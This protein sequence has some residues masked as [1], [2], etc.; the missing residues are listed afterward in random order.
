MTRKY[1]KQYGWVEVT[2]Q[3]STFLTAAVAG[4]GL[5]GGRGGREHDRGLGEVL[6]RE[7][8][9]QPRPRHGRAG[10]HHELLLQGQ[11]HAPRAERELGINNR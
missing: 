8:G 9:D 4:A 5:A 6:R 1:Y 10:G 3:S 11:R 7:G 2:G